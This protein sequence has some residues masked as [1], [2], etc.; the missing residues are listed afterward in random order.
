MYVCKTVKKYVNIEM[1][2]QVN[3]IRGEQKNKTS[4]KV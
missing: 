1:L 4:K 3:C 2:L